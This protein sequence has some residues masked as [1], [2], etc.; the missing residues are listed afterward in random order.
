MTTSISDFLI[1]AGVLL[2]LF[3]FAYTAYR[4]QG[5]IDT[6]NEIKDAFA[7]RAEAI[8]IG[9]EIPYK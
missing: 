9:G 5:L 7:E 3:F 6:V 2:G 8:P 4:Q 1:T